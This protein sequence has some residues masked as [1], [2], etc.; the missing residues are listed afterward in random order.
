MLYDMR[1]KKEALLRMGVEQKE[2]SEL[3]DDCTFKPEITKKKVA[4]P[5]GDV[6]QRNLEWAEKK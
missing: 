3:T 5:D 6:I 4:V 2:K 1:H